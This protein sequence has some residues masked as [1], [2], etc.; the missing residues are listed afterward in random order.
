MEAQIV[1][2]ALFLVM[3]LLFMV[4]YDSNPTL[5]RFVMRLLRRGGKMGKGDQETATVI[6]PEGSISE[7]QGNL[8]TASPAIAGEASPILEQQEN[9]TVPSS[10]ELEGKKKRSRG[11]ASQMMGVVRRRDKAPAK[12][13]GETVSPSGEPVLDG[14]RKQG[15]IAR[16]LSEMIPRGGGRD[17]EMEEMVMAAVGDVRSM[18]D[19]LVNR[20][21]QT[22]EAAGK[23][24]QLE[25]G[26]AKA[27]DDTMM[28]SEEMKDI[29]GS[30][31]VSIDGLESRLNELN[32][33][34]QIVKNSEP[35]VVESQIKEIEIVDEETKN[36]VKRLE[37]ALAD[38]NETLE[39]L[40]EKVDEAMND[41]RDVG[42]RLGVI[43][44]NLQTTIGFNIRKT[45]RCESCGSSGYVAS[46]VTCSNCGTGSWWGWWPEKESEGEVSDLEE[47]DL[48]EAF[49]IYE[50]EG[51][52]IEPEIEAIQLESDQS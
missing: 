5:Q 14:E 22:E 34:I 31:R 29:L 37:E 13:P 32:S 47:A 16:R 33:E 49:D 28:V 36:K 19:E 6:R 17:S 48:E 50:E 43:S 38:V 21:V 27:E 11:I 45:F 24:T 12:T 44:G 20:M 51:E 4:V 35:Q 18:V 39:S 10:V 30:I 26:L 7:Q 15:G 2:S 46:Q 42:E 40:P 25:E 23:I 41:A 9:L 8:A 1:S 3:L 52:D